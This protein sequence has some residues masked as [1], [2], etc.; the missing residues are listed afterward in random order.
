LQ[1][2]FS[3]YL[4]DGKRPRICDKPLNDYIVR[5]AV[6]IAGQAN[7]PGSFSKQG[8]VFKPNFRYVQSNSIPALATVISL[9]VWQTLH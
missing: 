3:K 8:V 9:S 5:T 6:K 4:D 7:K 2:L 1:A